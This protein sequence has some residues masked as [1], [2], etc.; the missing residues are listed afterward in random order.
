MALH[1]GLI[2]RRQSWKGRSLF[3]TGPTLFMRRFRGIEATFLKHGL[4]MWAV[5]SNTVPVFLRFLNPLSSVET[6]IQGVQNLLMAREALF[7]AKKIYPF[8]G[9]V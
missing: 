8:L 2:F 9:N 1:T 3:V 6:L 7:H 5:T 4:I